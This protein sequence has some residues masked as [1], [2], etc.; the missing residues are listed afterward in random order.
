[1]ATSHI[2]HVKRR[3][4]QWPKQRHVLSL[5]TKTNTLFYRNQ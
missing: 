1:M 3:I 2:P 5:M 4:K